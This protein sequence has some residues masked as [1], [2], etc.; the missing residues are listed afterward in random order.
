M[1]WQDGV[2]VNVTEHG[3]GEDRHLQRLKV[4]PQ[5]LINSNVRE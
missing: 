5:N 2:L 4:L 3:T 1:R